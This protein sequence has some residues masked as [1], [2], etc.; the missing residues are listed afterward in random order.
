M[1]LFKARPDRRPEKRITRLRRSPLV[2]FL[3]CLIVFCTT[4]AMILPAITLEK[5][6]YCG[7]TEHMHTDECYET[8]LVCP[9]GADESDAAQETHTER[10]LVCTR[11]ECEAHQHSPECYETVRELVCGLPEGEGHTHGPEC[12]ETV[13]EYVCG[14][15]ECEGHKHGPEC[16]ESVTELVCPLEEREG[17]THTDECFETVTEL[18]CTNTDPDHVHTDECYTT[19]RRQICPLDDY[20]GHKHGPECWQTKEVLVCTEEEREGHTHTAECE[21]TTERLICELPECEAH[22][23]T[24]ACYRETQQLVCGREECEGHTHTDECY[25]IV[26]VT[27]EQPAEDPETEAHVH[28]EECYERVLVCG[29]EEHQHTAQCYSNPAADLETAAVWEATLPKEEEMT[30]FWPEDLIR[31]AES[32]LDYTESGSNYHAEEKRNKGYSRYGA[33]YGDPY[34][35]WCAMFVSFCLNYAG[36][37]REYVPYDCNCANWVKT[38]TEK[39][40]YLPA[41][42]DSL[43]RPGDIIFF[44]RDQD[45]GSDHVGIVTAVDEEKG[46]D[47]IEG[48]SSDKVIR[49]HYDWDDTQVMGYGLLPESEFVHT[50]VAEDGSLLT[51]FTGE[52]DAMS[53]RAE[54]PADAFPEKTSMRIAEVNSGDVM[55][56]VTEAVEGD[57]V[58][59]NAVDISFVCEVE[60]AEGV[61]AEVEVEP[62]LP[63]RV[64]LEA[65][66]RTASSDPVLVHVPDEGAAQPVNLA[67]PAEDEEGILFEAD[68][69]SVYALVYTTDFS[70]S[71]DGRTYEFSL[72][73]GGY[74]QLSD[75]AEALGILESA[76]FRDAQSFAAE[77]ES[78]VFSDTDL[79]WVG[80]I[81][82]DTTLGEI[83]EQ[84]G[85]TAQYSAELTDEEIEELN[86]SEI[87]SGDWVLISL[88]PFDTQESLT[89][90]MKNG[91][92]FTV[93]V[94]DAANS[95]D[96]LGLDEKQYAIVSKRSD[97][98]NYQAVSDLRSEALISASR[99]YPLTATVV[100]LAESGEETYYSGMATEWT[101]EFDEKIDENSAWYYVS[102]DGKYL[103]ISGDTKVNNTDALTLPTQKGTASRIK[104]TKQDDGT[105][106]FENSSGLKLWNYSSA[107]SGANLF[108]VDSTDDGKHAWQM[109]LLAAEPEQG[110]GQGGSSGGNNRLEIGEPEGS[111]TLTPNLNP[112][113]TED[114]T[115]TLT[116]SVTPKSNKSS[117][118]EVHKSNVLVVMDRSSS[119][120]T[121]M[122]SDDQKVWYYGTRNTATWRADVNTY[123]NGQYRGYEFFADEACTIPLNVNFGFSWD[124]PTITY[125]WGQPYDSNAPIYCRSKTTRMVAEQEALRDL[126][127][128]LSAFNTDPENPDVVEMRVISFGDQRFDY[129]KPWGGGTESAWTD[130]DMAG[131]IAAADLNHYTSGTNWEEALQYAK[132]VMDQKKA[133]DGEDEDYYIIFLT[134]GEP[135]AI[136]GESGKAWHSDNPLEGGGNI[137]AYDAAKDDGQALVDAGY[138]FYNIFTYRKNEDI[139]YSYYLT[140]YA[141]GNGDYNQNATAETDEYFSDARTVDA[142]R[143]AFDHIFRTLTATIGHTNV[144]VSDGLTTDAMT[145]TVVSGRTNGY[146]Y[147]VAD[148]NGDTVYTV[149]AT[150]DIANPT[151]TFTVDG[152]PYPAQRHEG[153]QGVYYSVTVDDVEYSMALADV[154]S[155]GELT[156]DLS[157]L[158]MLAGDHTYSVSFIVWPDQDAYDYV[159]A[160][161]NGLTG[162]TW[163]EDASTYEDL[164]STKGYEKGGVE[165]YPSIVKYPNGVFAVLSNTE[166]KI[167]YSV[168]TVYTNEDPVVEGPFTIELPLPEP[169]PL[170]ASKAQL[171]KIWNVE[172]DPGALAQLLYNLDGS[173]KQYALVFEVL[174]DSATTPYKS[175]TLGWDAEQQKY[176]WDEETEQDV[177]YNDREVTIGTHWASDFAIATGLMLSTAR[178]DELGL[179]KTAYPSAT[180]NNETY[181]ILEE[182]HDYTIREPSLTFNFDFS[183]PT[184]HP[185]LVDGEMQSVNF[186]KEG[187][188]YTI[189]KI[190]PIATDEEGMSTL[191][192]ENTLRGNI[193]LNKQVLDA[194]GET[195]DPNDDTHFTYTIV[196][197]NNSDPGPFTIEGSH[198]PWYGIDGLFYHTNDASGLPDRYFQARPNGTG[199]VVLKDESGNTYDAV[200]AGDFAEEVGPAE[201]TYTDSAGVSQTIQ[202][203]GNQMNHDSDN[204]VTT[205]MRIN[206]AQTLT[207]ANVPVGTIYT[208]TEADETGYDLVRIDREIRVDAD[209]QAE[210]SD[211]ISGSAVIEGQIVANRDNH[212]TYYNRS[213]TVDI[214]IQKTDTEGAG[215]AGAVFQLKSVNGSQESDVEDVIG[216]GEVTKTIDGEEVTFTSAF[217]T[218][219]GVQTLSRLPDGIYRL[220]EVY[221]PE[222][223]VT[224]FRYIQFTI[225]NREMKDVTT[226]KGESNKLEFTASN[227]SDPALLKIANKRGEELPMTG[228]IGTGIYSLLGGLLT[229]GA[230]G[231]YGCGLRRRREGGG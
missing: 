148:E 173:S 146:V 2:R 108:F 85:L 11:E 83:K 195:I 184:Y 39:K 103:T 216:L 112:D 22:T 36:I 70:Y 176:I 221:V 55:D 182:G 113:G 99:G 185:M 228:G 93:T 69:F 206:Q 89:V 28:T 88:Q 5:Q 58:Y 197:E 8:R 104:I 135:T 128:Q 45:S 90:T 123:Y 193:S 41:G 71:V 132:E 74:I 205:V 6:T 97:N 203:Y 115:Y 68:S 127:S 42:G 65:K 172:S 4:Y 209:S 51:V 31:V 53:V 226:D 59:V 106:S 231:F 79:V 37:S 73:G 125:S 46:I 14:K 10:V 77:V 43:P 169:M 126:V 188:T 214:T 161:N 178:M 57:V 80:K 130:G 217:E 3:A 140:N 76:K 223:Y 155:S 67:E 27:E 109:N 30:G 21:R 12:Y 111:K 101:F 92:V 175:V 122:V 26:E 186:T 82:E 95:N 54:A 189:T 196:L 191:V 9:L 171:E 160:L 157:A 134:D 202:L 44:N 84:E 38:L 40:M 119:M 174:R 149:E 133:S 110:G 227:G 121:N 199:R 222:G 87:A 100:S 81:D 144:T 7:F 33:W 129:P 114:G 1:N 220:Y 153:E 230:I 24:D 210:E 162:Y 167:E 96:P 102:S 60:E 152:T 170:T 34:G 212:V 64:A 13:T 211:S 25:E 158:G 66:G 163:S 52:T 219:G 86:A 208:I 154:D 137:V 15:E 118:T 151:V 49:R 181:Y 147:S 48:N 32:Q 168:T 35:D 183:A 91:D 179:D 117:K 229:A 72:S 141:Y 105:Y 177:P 20:V 180:Y 192:I 107:A 47:T 63:V 16:Y 156:W 225:E 124:N 187:N 17:H 75:L 139:K 50:A 78:A 120:I 164:T 29:L 204:K 150:G 145:T 213:Y 207:I 218:T 61:K 198:V 224:T 94:T 200:C 18:T 143:D 98:D 23:H 190:E 165:Q 19:T 138:A 56:A 215:L 62:A 131:A 116:L 159:A 136:R 166:Q 194:D 142:L 201:I